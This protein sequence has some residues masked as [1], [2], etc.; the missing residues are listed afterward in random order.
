MTRTRITKSKRIN[1]GKRQQLLEIA[2]KLA[3]IRKDVW[4]EFGGI[5]GL[6]ITPYEARNEWIKRTVQLPARLWKATMVDALDNI[7]AYREAAKI[8][9]KKAIKSRPS[10]KQK[11]LYQMLKRNDWQGNNFLHRQMRKV[12]VRGISTVNNQIVLDSGSYRWFLRNGQGWI[13]IQS[14]EKGKR[15]H[16]PLTSNYELTGNLRLIIGKQV[17]VHYTIEVETLK[18]CG[19]RVIG[20]DKGYTEAFADSDGDFHGVGLG[21]ELSEYSNKLKIKYQRRNKLYALSQKNASIAK[22]NLGTKKMEKLA[23]RHKNKIKDIVYKAANAVV[24]KALVVVCEDLTSP[25]ANN[26]PMGKNVNRR[27]SSW[28][29]GIIAS[30][31]SDVTIRRCSA[32]CLVSGAYTSQMDSSIKVLLGKR[33]GD[34]FYHYNGDVSQADTNA[35]RNI[36]GRYYDDE[37]YQYMPYK[38]VKEVLVRRTELFMAESHKLQTVGSQL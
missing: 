15:I 2:G 37:I 36:L 17:I 34:K 10:E 3:V 23:R 29:K 1:E 12:F 5:S 26:K 21:K 33:V 13:A 28:T 32:V 4:K 27:L 24:D 35:A 25:I 18:T 7:K 11:E 30:A 8:T 31:L 20:V 14:L 38:A 6:S 22:H 19:D 9:V 16:I